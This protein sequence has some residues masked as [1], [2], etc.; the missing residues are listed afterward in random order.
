VKELADIARE[1]PFWAVRLAAI[2]TIANIDAEAAIEPARTAAADANSRVRRAAIRILGEMG[3]PAMVPFFR[4]RFEADDSYQV[5]A[6]A[7]RAIGRSGDRSQHGFLRQASEM[8]SYRDVIRS[9]ALWAIEEL[10]G[11][12]SP[13]P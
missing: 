2:E 9:A 13:R 8:P 11:G 3:D 1:D 5:Q 6:E 10:A 12:H 4:S 7:L